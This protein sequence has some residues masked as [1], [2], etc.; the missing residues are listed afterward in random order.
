MPRK[1]HRCWSAAIIAVPP[2][3]P[4]GFSLASNYLWRF[5]GRAGPKLN[6]FSPSRRRPR[7]TAA[8]GSGRARC[9]CLMASD[10]WAFY[11]TICQLALNRGSSR[12][13]R[14]PSLYA[15]RQVGTVHGRRNEGTAAGIRKRG[16]TYP[17]STR[18][19]LFDQWPRNTG[20]QSSLFWGS[21][22]KVGSN[23]A[24]STSQKLQKISRKGW[25]ISYLR[26]VCLLCWKCSISTGLPP[27]SSPGATLR[28]SSGPKQSGHRTSCIGVMECSGQAP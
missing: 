20:S 24:K 23:E 9:C 16:K 26:N 10:R 12:V 8:A 22:K 27:H 17:R 5:S 4:R 28:T 15:G 13:E 3:S 14:H 2:S 21:P 1:R 25:K 19:S 18:D 6:F 11:A 7:S